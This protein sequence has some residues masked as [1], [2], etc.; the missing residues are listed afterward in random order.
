[1]TSEKPQDGFWEL[2]A[3]PAPA[4]PSHATTRRRGRPRRSRRAVRAQGVPLTAGGGHQPRLQCAEVRGQG[5]RDF[6]SLFLAALCHD[7]R[8]GHNWSA[9]S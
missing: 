6:L 9:L 8:I 2:K 4:R 7:F 5:H 3:P 1:M